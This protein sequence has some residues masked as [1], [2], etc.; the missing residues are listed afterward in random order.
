MGA[1]ARIEAAFRLTELAR[2]TAMAGIRARHPHYTP[3]QVTLALARL[4]LGDGLT[5]RVWPLE[6]LVEP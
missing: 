3:G 1:T 5:R 4:V 6:E 2:H